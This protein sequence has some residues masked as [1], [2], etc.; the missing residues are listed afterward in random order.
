MTRGRPPK[1]KR[2]IS[3]LRNQPAPST[4]IPLTPIPESAEQ[5]A[6][7]YQDSKHVEEGGHGQHQQD[8]KDLASS[9]Q[10]GDLDSEFESDDEWKGLT[11]KELGKKL[12]ALSI[13][14]Q[15]DWIPYTTKFSSKN[16]GAP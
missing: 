12:V 5:N 4:S 13:M 15:T 1:K 14:I 2:N 9:E 16:F 6:D 10:E 11:S 3:G 7:R 8:M